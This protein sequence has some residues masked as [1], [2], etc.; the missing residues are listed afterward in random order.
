[1]RRSV[2][3]IC[4]AVAPAL[5]GSIL[6]APNVT[7]QGRLP[8]AAVMGG[9]R[10]RVTYAGMRR[11]V[12]TLVSINRDTLVARWPSG[13]TSRMAMARVTELDVSMGRFPQ[14][15]LGAQVGG[16]IGLVGGVVVSAATHKGVGV[17]LDCAVLGLIVGGVVGMVRPRD[18]WRPWQGERPGP[19]WGMR[20]GLVSSALRAETRVGMSRSF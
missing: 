8:R 11:R 3:L 1:M 9:T 13:A 17:A 15:K 4:L 19:A 2:R 10:V 20:V 18:S 6:F 12:G 14:P 7:A 5:A 16:A